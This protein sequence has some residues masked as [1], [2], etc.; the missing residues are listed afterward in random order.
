MNLIAVL[1]P[2]NLTRFLKV[3]LILLNLISGVWLD[4]NAIFYYIQQVIHIIDT[5]GLKISELVQ[6]RIFQFSMGR[7]NSLINDQGFRV[8]S[9]LI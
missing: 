8:I 1:T 9:L 7:W 5:L 4:R 2:Y 6:L 3:S